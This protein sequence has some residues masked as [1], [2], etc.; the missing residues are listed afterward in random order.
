MRRFSTSNGPSRRQV[1]RLLVGKINTRLM[2]IDRAATRV[3]QQQIATDTVVVVGVRGSGVRVSVGGVSELST[4]KLETIKR[5]R[6]RIQ[7]FASC[8][9][10]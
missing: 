9:K 2:E 10:S 4:Q 3:C 8:V 7:I 1:G 6:R 5:Q